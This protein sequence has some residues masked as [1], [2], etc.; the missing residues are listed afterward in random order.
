MFSSSQTI[1]NYTNAIRKCIAETKYQFVILIDSLDVALHLNNFDWL[2]IQLNDKVK[3][4]LTIGSNVQS[5]DDCTSTDNRTLFLLKNKLAASSFVHLNQFSEQQWNE[6]LSCG[7]GNFYST[8]AHLQLPDSWKSCDERIPL[9][10]KVGAVAVY[11]LFRLEKLN[12]TF[13]FSFSFYSCCGGLHGWAKL[14]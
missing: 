8:N 5:V 1:Q 7:G 11:F 3:I 10:A 13:F 2:P 6:V 4:I 12:F 9:K 14:I